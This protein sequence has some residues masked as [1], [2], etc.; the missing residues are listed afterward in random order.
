MPFNA[1]EQTQITSILAQ[2][3]GLSPELSGGVPLSPFEQEAYLKKF[4]FSALIWN[5]FYFHAMGDTVFLWISIA[6]SVFVVT[7]PV[8]I[9]L[10]F[11]ARRRAWESPKRTWRDFN[12]FQAVQ[13]KWDKTSWIGLIA[14]IIGTWITGQLLANAMGNATKSLGGDGTLNAATLQNLQSNLN[15]N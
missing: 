1:E 3:Q 10:A 2:S 6:C 13:R 8:L 9:V 14:L 15:D 11:L 12:E 4:S 5:A 7:L